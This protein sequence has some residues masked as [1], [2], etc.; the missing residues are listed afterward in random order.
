V[1]DDEES[2]PVCPMLGFN[3]EVVVSG[4]SYPYYACRPILE[5]PDVAAC[6]WWDEGYY[7]RRHGFTVALFRTAPDKPLGETSY[8]V[9][10]TS[11]GEIMSVDDALQAQAVIF[12]LIETT[13]LPR[14]VNDNAA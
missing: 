7:T 13:I 11:I 4:T 1:N 14:E 12:H 10:L 5:R 9:G 8:S 2:R 6:V 3:D